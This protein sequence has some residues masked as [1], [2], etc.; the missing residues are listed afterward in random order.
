GGHAER[1]RADRRA[2][3]EHAAPARIVLRRLQDEVA[4]RLVQPVDRLRMLELL[5]PLQTRGPRLEQPHFA[6]GAIELALFR[7][8]STRLPR[9]MN[10][11]DE[12]QPRVAAIGK[13]DRNFTVPQFLNLSHGGSS[14]RFL[15]TLRHQPKHRR[16]ITCYIE[17]SNWTEVSDRS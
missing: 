14:W 12:D 15:A 8:V 3:R 10:D 16:R 7:R 9:R 4:A 6:K 13:L 5:E 11:P 17:R 1:I 2:Q